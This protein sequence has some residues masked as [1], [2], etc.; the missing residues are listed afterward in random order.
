MGTIPARTS[1]IELPVS[2]D[3]RLHYNNVRRERGNDESKNYSDV[4]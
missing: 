2:K 1:P 4:H 3:A